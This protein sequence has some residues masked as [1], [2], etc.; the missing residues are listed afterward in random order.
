MGEEK[1]TKTDIAFL[2]EEGV[3]N[4]HFELTNR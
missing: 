2:V 3:G 1:M 4:P